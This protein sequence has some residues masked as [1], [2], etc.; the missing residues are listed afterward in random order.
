MY[1][2]FIY[3]LLFVCSILLFVGHSDWCANLLYCDI[4]SVAVDGNQ[5]HNISKVGLY[6]MTLL[7]HNW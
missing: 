2:L 5:T 6:I 3:C 4:C 1:C 7:G